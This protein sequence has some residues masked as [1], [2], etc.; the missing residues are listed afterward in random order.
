VSALDHALDYAARGLPVFP[1]NPTSAKPKAK[2]P[3][4]PNG[5]KDATTDPEKIRAWWERWPLALI[6]AAMGPASGVFAIDPDVPK[7][8]GD[9]DG[10][11]AWNAL[12]AAHGGVPLTHTHETP[13]GGRHFLFAMPEGLRITNKTGGLPKGID[14]RGDGGYVIMAPSRMADGR[15]YQ[16]ADEFDMGR[17]AP[18]PGWLLD[19]ITAEPE[20][21]EKPQPEPKPDLEPRNR[22]LGSHVDRRIERYVACAVDKECEAVANCGRGGRNN[23]LN[24][25]AFNLG[26]LVGAN[27]LGSGEATRQLYAAA[28]TAGLVKADGQRAVM[29]TIES[30]MTS[31]AAKPRDMSKVFDRSRQSTRSR[32]DAADPGLGDNI[33]LVTEDEAAIRFAERYRGKLRYCHDH[34]AW[35]EWSGSI[36]KRNGTGLAFHFARE[37]ARQLVDGEEAKV[38]VQGSKAAFA[39]AV[40][41][42][43]RADPT[44]AVTAEA[45]DRDPWLLGTPGGTVDLRTGALRPAKPEDGITRST[46]VVPSDV[47]ECPLWLRFLHETTGGDAEMIRFAQQWAGYSLTGDTREHALVFV[48]GDG[49]N[50]KSVYVN[51]HVGLAGDYAVTASMD[52]FIASSGDRHPTDLAML[53]GARLVTAS[54]TEEGRQWAESRIKQLTGGDRITAR[55]M[56]QDFFT[57]LPSFKLTIIGNHKPGLRNVDDAARR[58]FNLVPFTRKPATP[59]R[60][61]EEKLK[62]EWPGILRWMIEG[63]LDWQQNGLVRP[64]SVKAATEAYFDEQDLIGEWLD[65]KCIVDRHNPHRMATTQEL[66]ASWSAYAKA[67]NEPAGTERAFSQRLEKHGFVRKNK[68]PSF[69]GKRVRGFSGIEV[70]PDPLQQRQAAE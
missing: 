22:D 41:R 43:A 2:T 57:F 65:E 26:T 18:P 3:L 55:F 46:A 4:T 38:R 37:L 8:P 7:E 42:F 20:K 31:G 28:D 61:L 68:V 63:C 67:A 40:E 24:T 48:F 45:W 30:G 14:C 21:A 10:L 29:A 66:F 5:F 51:V 47:A 56:R 17:F 33:P 19:L 12:A 39:G 16:F 11:A 52:V 70:R 13:S 64:E 58:R 6:G 1:C 35:F 69:D 60:Q 53:R 23:Q 54:E 32:S 59:D 36:W 25:S 34:G 49:G 62:A 15:V 44:L 27:V 9:P 50:G